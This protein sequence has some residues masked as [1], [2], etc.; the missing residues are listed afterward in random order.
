MGFFNLKTSIGTTNQMLG[1][2]F[3]LKSLNVSRHCTRAS[4]YRFTHKGLLESVQEG[5][6]KLNSSNRTLTDR[7]RKFEEFVSSN[8]VQWNDVD[9]VIVGY[10]G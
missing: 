1:G 4:T 6:G 9:L 10:I 5:H 2:V 3:G 8:T 7:A